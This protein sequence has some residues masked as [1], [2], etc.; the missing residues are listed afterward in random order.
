MKI[1][2]WILVTMLALT[3]MARAATNDLTG[4][5]QKGLF[6]EEANRDLNAAIADY[7]SVAGAFDKDRQLAATAIFRLG[8]CYR[9][10]GKNNEATVQYQRIIKEFS[11]QP[12]LVNL[13][14]Q[15][16]AG[17]GTEPKPSDNGSPDSALLDAEA[18]VASLQTQ[19]A[20][21]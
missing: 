21:D 19:I 1:K 4:L 10:L 8:E 16:L 17:M 7:Q 20:K 15:N 14:R 6:D 18:N 5:L 3:A 11:D 9:K 2:L 12:T 13:S